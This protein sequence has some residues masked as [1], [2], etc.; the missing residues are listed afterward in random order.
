[1]MATALSTQALPKKT[2]ANTTTQPPRRKKNPK[3]QNLSCKPKSQIDEIPKTSI[4]ASA[5]I[6]K[7]RK[8]VPE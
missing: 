8:C 7:V 2:T 4:K 6:S 1:M 3:Q 5:T